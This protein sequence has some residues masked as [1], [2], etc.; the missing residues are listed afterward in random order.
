MAEQLHE[1]LTLPSTV[2]RQ[3]DAGWGRARGG[4]QADQL[5]GLSPAALEQTGETTTW[6]GA[7]ARRPNAKR[8]I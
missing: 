6:K 8:I 2:F 5:T 1:S 4:L 7:G 3:I